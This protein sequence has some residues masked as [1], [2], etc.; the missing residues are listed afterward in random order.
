MQAKVRP[1]DKLENA[2]EYLLS[3]NYLEAKIV[4][5][6]ASFDINYC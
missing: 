5:I 1:K 6:V 3:E 4:I 2:I